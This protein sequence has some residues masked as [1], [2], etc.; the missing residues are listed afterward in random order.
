VSIWTHLPQQRHGIAALELLL[1]RSFAA[2]DQP[3]Q[4]VAVLR[5]LYP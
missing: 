3:R 4:L 2:S 1:E 5:A